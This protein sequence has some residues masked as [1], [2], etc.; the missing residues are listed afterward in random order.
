MQTLA[1]E[2]VREGGD[3]VGLRRVERNRFRAERAFERFER[4]AVARR[5]DDAPAR[6]AVLTDE[7]MADAARCAY[8]QCCSHVIR[9]SESA[10]ADRYD[11]GRQARTMNAR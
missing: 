10:A 1:R 8:D 11:L 2:S 6:L 5:G 7:L 9:P 4:P 3:F